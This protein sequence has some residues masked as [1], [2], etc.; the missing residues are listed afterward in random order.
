MPR[1]DADIEM[2]MPVGQVAPDTAE[3]DA[4]GDPAPINVAGVS[5]LPGAVASTDRFAAS[6]GGGTTP[7]PTRSTRTWAAAPPGEAV[8]SRSSEAFRALGMVGRSD[9]PACFSAVEHLS[10]IAA[11]YHTSAADSTPPQTGVFKATG[12]GSV[13]RPSPAASTP[14]STTTPRQQR[15]QQDS[16]TAVRLISVAVIGA[17]GGG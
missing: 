2:M 8:N 10:L 7:T 1:G 15:L 11:G 14:S 13:H 4:T 5:N 6:L 16:Q 17:G 12:D 3:P 9:D